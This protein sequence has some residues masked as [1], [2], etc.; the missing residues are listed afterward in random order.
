M[1]S[2]GR[3]TV[4]RMLGRVGCSCRAGFNVSLHLHTRPLLLLYR[5]RNV[6]ARQEGDPTVWPYGPTINAAQVTW[7]AV[8]AILYCGDGTG[9]H[10]C[11]VLDTHHGTVLYDDMQRGGHMWQVG[12]MDEHFFSKY[13][14]DSSGWY[15]HEVVYLQKGAVGDYRTLL[16]MH[17][18]LT[19]PDC[20]LGD[21]TQKVWAGQFHFQGRNVFGK[22]PPGR[23]VH[24]D[25]RNVPLDPDGYH[26]YCEVCGDGGELHMCCRS[27][28]EGC[29]R[30]Y[31]NDSH[32]KLPDWCVQPVRN[33]RWK[34]PVCQKVEEDEAQHGAIHELPGK[35]PH[36]RDAARDR[37]ELRRTRALKQYDEYLHAFRVWSDEEQ[38]NTGATVRHHMTR[39]SLRNYLL[40]A[41]S[42]QYARWAADAFEL[43]V[44]PSRYAQ[45][46]E[47]W[48]TW[49]GSG[50]APERSE[51]WYAVP[52]V[53]VDDDE[54]DLSGPDALELF[55]PGP[56]ET[57]SVPSSK[58]EHKRKVRWL[59]DT[60]D[61]ELDVDLLCRPDVEV[62]MVQRRRSS[63]SARGRPGR[64]V[65]LTDSDTEGGREVGRKVEDVSMVLTESGMEGSEE[66]ER[67]GSRRQSGESGGKGGK[68]KRRRSGQWAGCGP[69]RGPRRTQQRQ[70]R[71]SG[72]NSEVVARTV[73]RD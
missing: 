43:E 50:V 3:P 19:L 18:A 24:P 4:E 42:E 13:A 15:I 8:A 5:L 71:G 30:V 16:A 25:N 26:K 57:E 48:S 9:G 31:H 67:K 68:R 23:R 54:K 39:W 52:V 70:S 61:D 11:C 62:K 37:F 44:L 58:N 59:S 28:K 64:A 45:S 66:E 33:Q 20:G 46:F 14:D 6:G 2:V 40:A 36:P 69:G 1:A 41:T 56:E 10:Y 7:Q 49:R 21:I 47:S 34:C 51:W 55:G 53:D 12:P 32:C 65:V 35:V 72:S 17:E 22:E 60:E 27:G 73:A 63:G 38:G 29:G